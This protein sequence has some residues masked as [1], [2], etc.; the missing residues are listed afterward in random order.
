MSPDLFKQLGAGKKKKEQQKRILGYGGTQERSD[1]YRSTPWRTED[2]YS[3]C[4]QGRT[5]NG[6]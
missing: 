4:S 6:Q 1:F 5:Q 2:V 3:E